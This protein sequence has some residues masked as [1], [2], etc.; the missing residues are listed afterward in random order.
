MIQTTP[1][2]AH[3]PAAARMP[4]PG[5]G[6][7]GASPHLATMGTFFGIVLAL[8]DD[9]PVADMA[10]RLLALTQTQS[11]IMLGKLHCNEAFEPMIICHP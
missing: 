2:L 6:A 7:T 1:A 3:P 8:E 5:S 9:S 4:S 10:R 11:R